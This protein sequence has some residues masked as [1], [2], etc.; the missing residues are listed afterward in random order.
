MTACDSCGAV[1]EA[2]GDDCQRRFDALLALDHSRTEPWGSRHGLAFSAFALQHPDRFPPDVPA[3]AWIMLY[4]VY[5]QGG[6]YLRVTTALRRLGRQKPAWDVPP[7]P[8]RRQRANFEVTIADL[9]TFPADAYPKQL[10]L[11]CKSALDGWRQ[12]VEQ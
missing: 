3:R 1:Y 7:F 6:D 4:T 9:G 8:A 11:W 2:E 5:V 12:G 10:D